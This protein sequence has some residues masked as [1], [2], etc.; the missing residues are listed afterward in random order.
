MLHSLYQLSETYDGEIGAKGPT[1]TKAFGPL[2]RCRKLRLEEGTKI[3][4]HLFV[5]K[6]LFKRCRKL[7][8]SLRRYPI[9]LE[10]H[11]ED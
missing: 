3:P 6:S 4:H 9:K 7:R 11:I 1:T 10:Q 2:K 5:G 8:S